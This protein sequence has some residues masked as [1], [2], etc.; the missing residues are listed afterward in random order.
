MLAALAK[1]GE[2]VAREEDMDGSSAGS[3]VSSLLIGQSAQAERYKA[4]VLAV[5]GRRHLVGRPWRQARENHFV[6]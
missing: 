1:A 2:A 5:Y 6:R 3:V 4:R